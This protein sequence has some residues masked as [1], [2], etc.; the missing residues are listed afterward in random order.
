MFLL[1]RMSRL[2]VTAVPCVLP[3]ALLGLL[4]TPRERKVLRLVRQYQRLMGLHQWDITVQFA[5]DKSVASCNADDE[6]MQAVLT[7]DL[8][9]LAPSDDAATVRHELLHCMTWE[10]IRVAEHLARS[11][12]M[13]KEMI[14]AASERCTTLL[15]RMPV[16]R[17]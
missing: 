12:R 6:Y 14:R 2:S 7:F 8:E 15:E 9:R 10:L 11:D 4:M 13:A 1:R 16:W 3:F 17:R 5:A